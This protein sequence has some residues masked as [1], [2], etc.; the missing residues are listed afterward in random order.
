[1]ERTMQ[2]TMKTETKAD[3]RG[4]LA[5]RLARELTRDELDNLCG[6]ILKCSGTGAKDLDYLK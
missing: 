1:M 5:R 2:K 3:S 4:I 6:G